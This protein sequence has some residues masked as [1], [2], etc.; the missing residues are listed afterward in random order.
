MRDQGSF[1]GQPRKKA[2]LKAIH[3]AAAAVSSRAAGCHPA[4]WAS[5]TETVRGCERV[6]RAVSTRA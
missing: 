5:A 3:G 2:A 1:R 6:R 4:G